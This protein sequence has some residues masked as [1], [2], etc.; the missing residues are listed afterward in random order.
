[1][2]E[3]VR[4][5]QCRIRRV[6][7]DDVNEVTRLLGALYAEL[8]EREAFPDYRLSS[9]EDVLRDSERTFGFVAHA[10]DQLMGVLMLTEGVA[11]Y[12][13]GVFGQITELYVEPEYR[14]QG[15]ASLLVRR[16]TQFGRERGWKRLDVG[17]PHQ[18]RWNRSLRFYESEG[19]FEVGPRL[20]LDL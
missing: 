12:A 18:P 14:S 19:F 3:K 15:I 1:M 2:N 10:G 4:S 20:K 11:V 7:A 6:T 5:I 9:V 16:A 17:A 8:H 13:G